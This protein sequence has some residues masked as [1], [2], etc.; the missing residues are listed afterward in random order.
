MRFFVTNAKAPYPWELAELGV[1]YGNLNAF[2]LD[3]Y[4][5][6]FDDFGAKH[7]CEL[8]LTRYISRYILKMK[9]G[10]RYDDSKNL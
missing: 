4:C 1:T 5:V 10:D 2:F 8:S 3:N 9:E 7:F 6:R